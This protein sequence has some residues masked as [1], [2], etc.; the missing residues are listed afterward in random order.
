[1]TATEI[2]AITSLIISGVMGLLTLRRQRKND[3]V[4]GEESEARQEKL[5]AEARQIG[6][7]IATAQIT[8]LV[9]EVERLQEEIDKLLAQSDLMSCRID[10]LELA[11]EERDERIAVLEAEV[12]RWKTRYK[13][14]SNWIRTQGVAA[15]KEGDCDEQGNTAREL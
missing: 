11:V 3:A 9:D 12:F 5:Y 8:R 4:Q 6:E 13:N 7:E 10:K 1:M 15:P 14:L 2:V